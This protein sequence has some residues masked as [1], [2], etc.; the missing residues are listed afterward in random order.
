MN[1]DNEIGE[2]IENKAELYAALAQAQG[3]F[4][5]VETDK[6]VDFSTRGGG[7]VKYNYA[8]FAAIFKMAQEPLSENGLS[9][10]Q[11][12]DNGNLITI[13]AHKSGQNISSISPLPTGSNDLKQL[14]ANLSYLRRYQYTAII[15]AVIADE[16]DENAVEG[17]VG[18]QHSTNGNSH[19]QKRQRPMSLDDI[20][21][22]IALDKY[23]GFTA[24]AIEKQHKFAVASLNKVGLGDDNYRHAFGDWAFGKASSKDW[25]NGECKFIIDWI[26]A[27]Q[28]NNYTATEDAKKEAQQIIDYLNEQADMNQEPEIAP[29]GEIPF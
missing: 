27:N 7:Q 1:I 16:D 29:E 2:V 26:G 3:Q 10:F 23:A 24:T 18:K 17:E 6:K 8:S 22:I 5:P 11:V 12:M 9:V 25:S 13:L 21:A 19:T 20:K 4:K 15:G 28:D 14:G